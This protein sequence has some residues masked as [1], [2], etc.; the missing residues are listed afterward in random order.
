PIEYRVI[1][2]DG[3]IAHLW[4]H[5]DASRD[6]TGQLVQVTGTVVDITQRILAETALRQGEDR[7]RTLI[8]KSADAISL[9]DSRARFRYVSPVCTA[10]L[11][12]QSDEIAGRSAR[13]LIHPEDQEPNE[14]LFLRLANSPGL[15]L[16]SQFRVRHRDRS[17]RWVDVT[18]TNHLTNPILEAI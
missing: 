5:G 12:Y 17:W 13:E 6:E 2:S 15:A 14:R 4:G 18:G 16:S 9:V 7:F 3:R 11:G 10:I 1:K 8:D